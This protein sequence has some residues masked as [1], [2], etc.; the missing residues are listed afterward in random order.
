[1]PPCANVSESP[2]S[3]PVKNIKKYWFYLFFKYSQTPGPAACDR[4]IRYVRVPRFFLQKTFYALSKYIFLTFIIII[5]PKT[6]TVGAKIT[7]YI[8]GR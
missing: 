6:S 7:M 1:M 4:G 2:P 3:S 8:R 5:G